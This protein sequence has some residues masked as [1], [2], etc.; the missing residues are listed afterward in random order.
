MV[1]SFLC[2]LWGFELYALGVVCMLAQQVR[3]SLNY[4]PSPRNKVSL[5]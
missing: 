1:P 4:L 3:Y 5:M 2:R